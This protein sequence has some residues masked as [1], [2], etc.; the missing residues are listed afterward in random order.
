M[1]AWG[2]GVAGPSHPQLVFF[3]LH[4]P[5]PED[6]QGDLAQRGEGTASRLHNRLGGRWGNANGLPGGYP[7]PARV[8]HPLHQLGSPLPRELGL[9]EAD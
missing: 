9:E 3:H 6:Y 4:H 1:W 5:C 8:T 7:G 2:L